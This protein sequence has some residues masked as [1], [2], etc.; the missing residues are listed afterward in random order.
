[1]GGELL[2]HFLRVHLSPRRYPR[3]ACATGPSQF[4]RKFS[5]NAKVL[6]RAV[7]IPFGQ[8]FVATPPFPPSWQLRVNIDF[9]SGGLTLLSRIPLPKQT[10]A[11]SLMASRQERLQVK[12]S[13]HCTSCTAMPRLSRKRSKCVPL[14]PPHSLYKS[15][16]FP[17][18]ECT[19]AMKLSPAFHSHQHAPISTTRVSQCQSPQ[20]PPT[21]TIY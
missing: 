15:P 19:R 12:N 2:I 10:R 20:K 16:N 13:E 3:N 4:P 1:M 7:S 5:K 8:H 14:M 21:P 9:H 18:L 6:S 17:L 11:H